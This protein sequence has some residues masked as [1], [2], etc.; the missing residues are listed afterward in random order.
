MQSEPFKIYSWLTSFIKPYKSELITLIF[1]GLLISLNSLLVPKVIGYLIDSSLVEEHLLQF[2]IVLSVMIL[3]TIIINFVIIP[4]QSFKQR[5]LQDYCSQDLQ[6]FILQHLRKLDMYYYENNPSGKLLSLLNTEV[7]NVQQLYSK[8]LPTFIQ[9]VLFAI[10]SIIFMLTTSVKL[11][12]ITIPALLVYYLFGPRIE[13]IA[14]TSGKNM[15]DNRI[16]L[17]QKIYESISAITEL[18]VNR[19]QNWDIENF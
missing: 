13:K 5:K 6:L 4:I 17:N 15:S 1:C 16:K 10:A 12:L 14:A 18:K 19:A 9:E 7:K 3:V 2:Y 11:T 8:L